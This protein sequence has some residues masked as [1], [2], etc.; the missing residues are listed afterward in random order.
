MQTQIKT[1]VFKIEMSYENKIIN[2][3]L[4]NLYSNWSKEKNWNEKKIKN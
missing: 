3:M 2:L 1:I 4:E